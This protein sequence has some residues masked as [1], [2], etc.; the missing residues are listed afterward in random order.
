MIFEWI[1]SSYFQNFLYGIEYLCM[2]KN[3][4]IKHS[5]LYDILELYRFRNE[6]SYCMFLSSQLYSGPWVERWCLLVHVDLL[7]LLLLWFFFCMVWFH[8]QWCSYV[9]THVFT[10]NFYFSFNMMEVVS[11]TILLYIQLLVTLVPN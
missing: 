5:R 9:R 7:I 3:R 8:D 1:I 4:E 10:N 2:I 11:D 6:K